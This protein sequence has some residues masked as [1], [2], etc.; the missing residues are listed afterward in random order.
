[1][2]ITGFF[3]TVQVIDKHNVPMLIDKMICAL[4]WSIHF[5]V[6]NQ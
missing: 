3:C 1:M 4:Q 5:N 6:D 2:V